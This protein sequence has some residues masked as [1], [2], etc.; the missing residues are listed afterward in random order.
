MTVFNYILLSLILMWLLLLLFFLIISPG[1]SMKWRQESQNCDN[2]VMQK[3]K[4]KKKKKFTTLPEG[5]QQNFL[6]E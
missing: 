2:F 6:Q 4:L 1:V 5:K 3:N